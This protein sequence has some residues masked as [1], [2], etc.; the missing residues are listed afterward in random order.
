LW[1]AGKNPPFCAKKE[2]SRISSFLFPPSPLFFL[3]GQPLAGARSSF[4]P[5][6]FSRLHTSLQMSTFPPK[7]EWFSLTP[8]PGDLLLL[9]LLSWIVCCR[10]LLA[11]L[12]NSGPPVASLVVFEATRKKVPFGLPQRFPPSTP[13]WM[14][15]TFKQGV[16]GRVLLP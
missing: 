4:T 6:E 8:F 16:Q 14:R 9:C 7:G 2:V 12:F 13:I 15:L 3:F 5:L 1:S 11:F 10:C